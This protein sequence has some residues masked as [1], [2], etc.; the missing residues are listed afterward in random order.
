MVDNRSAKSYLE[1]VETKLSRIDN[2][3][4]I[5]AIINETSLRLHRNLWS[6]ILLIDDDIVESLKKI[7]D[8]LNPGGGSLITEVDNTIQAINNRL[9]SPALDPAK[10]W[11]AT[12]RSNVDSKRYAFQHIVKDVHITWSGA[13]DEV[14]N[15]H[16][17]YNNLYNFANSFK[18]DGKIWDVTVDTTNPA[19]TAL[20][21]LNNIFSGDSAHPPRVPDGA[22]R[23]NAKYSVCDAN[24]EPL[25]K[26]GANY[27]INLW[28]Q[29]YEIENINIRADW[30]L[31]FQ[32]MHLINP[33]SLK[34]SPQ[35]I[36]LSINSTFDRT[37]VGISNMNVVCNKKFK[38]E[39]NDWNISLDI[40][41]R[42]TAFDNFNKWWAGW[43]LTVIQD[44]LKTELDEEQNW[45]KQKLQ[46]AAIERALRLDW[47]T[48]YD[49]LTEAQKA[50][51]LEQILREP[52][53]VNF[54]SIRWT[55]LKYSD[56]E[57][58]FIDNAR[59]RNKDNSIIRSQWTYKTYISNNLPDRINE[60]ISGELDK[61]LQR[62]AKNTKLKWRLT[63]FMNNIEDNKLDDNLNKRVSSKIKS[64]KNSDLYD[65]DRWPRSP[66]H[67]RDVNYMRFF[68]WSSTELRDQKVNIYTKLWEAEPVKYDLKMDISW[69]NNIAVEIKIDW[70]KDPI[71]LSS[72][73]PTALVRRILREQQI[74]Y[75]KV[76]AHIW[77]SIYKAMIQ[78]AKEK[79]FSLQYREKTWTRFID[80]DWDNII[81][82]KVKNLTTEEREDD[83]L[84]FSQEKFENTN[85]FGWGMNYSLEKWLLEIWK[86]FNYA[87]NQAHKQYR[88]WAERR[89][90][91][92]VNSR[93]R[94]RL[95]RSF[96]LSPIK[97]ILN[98]RNLTN[99]EFDTTVE[100]Q[101]K[102]IDISFSKN[103]FTLDMD[104]LE[105]PLVSKDLWKIL[106]KRQQKTRIFDWMERD[107]VE[108]VYI[109]IIDSLRQNAKVANTDF[110]VK[111]EITWNMFVL[112]KDGRFGMIPKE[113]LNPKKGVGT[114]MTWTKRWIRIFGVPVNTGTR[115]RKKFW[116]LNKERLDKSSMTI[117]EHWSTEEK[118][119]LRN[120]L[121]MQRFVKAMNRRMWLF[122]NIRALFVN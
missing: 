27:I 84:T 19:V 98:M 37:Q 71:C 76:R 79:N 119:L 8:Q 66:F 63:E 85:E 25:R 106:N 43:R 61:F 1:W 73:E 117:F 23:K 115:N 121:L 94:M 109:A 31:D 20:V 69:K 17:E 97:K 10:A 60:F 50:Q 30:N 2:M 55:Y 89:L 102:I 52:N 90:L 16:T 54:G 116:T 108:W 86:H 39:L 15:R 38:L 46:R 4:E 120:P 26:N 11:N 36:V 41:A 49:K 118:E 34:D 70:K 18:L 104:W 95:P 29:D 6:N 122:E 5:D 33:S 88:M 80:L 78:L 110:W 77:Y 32:S 113:D 114:P 35:E 51:F 47:G 99:F 105:K 13:K 45:W 93:S 101:W 74:K 9:A 112:N 65:M 59:S 68:S 44:S 22:W 7:S 107:I 87:M 111:D 103:K 58:W 3:W 28:W 91:W 42:R 21:D 92:I 24:W 12:I 75:W 62:N 67:N 53:M 96:W 14:V 48:L 57:N 100:S 83:I 82:R 64:K 40:G 81:V 72:W 56:F